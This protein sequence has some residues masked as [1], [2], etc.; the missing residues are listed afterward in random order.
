MA[1]R[2]A[3]ARRNKGAGACRSPLRRHSIFLAQRLHLRIAAG[4]RER[5]GSDIGGDF[6]RGMIAPQHLFVGGKRRRLGEQAL[7]SPWLRRAAISQD[8]PDR[9]WYWDALCRALLPLAGEGAA[10]ECH[11]SPAEGT[12]DLSTKM[13]SICSKRTRLCVP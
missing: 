1:A 11:F 5:G 4:S 7:R 8:C 3:L 13:F 9:G 10:V 12:V 6:G 2:P